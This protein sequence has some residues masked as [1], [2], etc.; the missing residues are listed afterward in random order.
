MLKRTAAIWILNAL[1]VVGAVGTLTAQAPAGAGAAKGKGAPKAAPAKVTPA[2]PGLFFKEVWKQNVNGS[3]LPLSQ[4]NVSNPDLELKLYGNTGEGIL[5]VGFDNQDQNPVHTWSGVCETGCMFALRHKTK[6]ADLTG[7]TRLRVNVKTSGFHKIH[8]AVKTA[9]G[10]WMVADVEIGTPADWLVTEL[11]FSEMKWLRLNPAKVTTSGNWIAT[12]DLSAI[13]EIG[14][15]DLT[16]GSGHGPGG[17]A[18]VAQ[19]EIYANSKP[20]E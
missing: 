5:M 15:V 7:Q 1:I 14:F 6:L 17:W 19:I 9:E 4:A 10:V 2:R 8:P 16:P 20:R 11:A 13:D 3:E 12:P 18:D